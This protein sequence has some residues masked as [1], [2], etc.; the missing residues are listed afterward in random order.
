MASL[1][2]SSYGAWSGDPACKHADIPQGAGCTIQTD[3]LVHAAGVHAEKCVILDWARHSEP[4]T[5][6]GGAKF[7]E[8]KFRR[9]AERY[10][11]FLL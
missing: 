8:G 4:F 10:E 2:S 7:L 1:L 9:L 3:K 6:D 11:F 5:S